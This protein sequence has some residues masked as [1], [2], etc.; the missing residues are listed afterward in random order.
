MSESTERSTL[1]LSPPTR[2]SLSDEVIER[3]REAILN[4]RIAPGEQLRENSLAESMGISRGPVREALRRLER[5]GLVIMRPNR[6][7][8]VARL[9]RQDLEEVFSLRSVLERLAAQYACRNATPADWNEM[10]T[11]IDEMAR[12][13]AKGITEQQAAELDLGFHDSLYR[14]SR[15]QRLLVCWSDLRP[16]I[17]V[18]LLS[19]NVADSDFRDVAVRGH[20][21]ILEAVKERD[22]KCA[23]SIIERHLQ[24]GYARVVGSYGR[25]MSQPSAK[26][27]AAAQG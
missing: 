23:V 22:E 13:I 20:Q 10:Q 5:E 8:V 16:Q 7:A 14:A 2:R 27:F 3:L 26:Q 25:Q 12:C 6:T 17:H 24:T 9:S 21:E 11:V 4:G 19:R 15:H 1:A 18:F